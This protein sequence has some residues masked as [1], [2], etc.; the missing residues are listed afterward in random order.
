[1]RRTLTITCHWTV[2]F[3]LVL[4]ISEA[5]WAWMYWLF[6]TASLTMVGLALT[7]GLMSR[8]GP[9]LPP[10]ARRAH[11]WMHR[12]MYGLLAWVGGITIYAQLTDAFTAREL[13]QWYLILSAAGMLHAI[14][15]LWRHTAL[16]DGAL[17]VITPD[18][19]HKH[20]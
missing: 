8:P 13:F 4:L 11:P 10:I 6:G 16:N 7:H 12:V 5:Q 18:V 14:F 2:G 19:L 20:L 9:Q 1:M 3:L 15:H 17:R